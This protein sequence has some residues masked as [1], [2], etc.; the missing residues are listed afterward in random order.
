MDQYNEVFKKMLDSIYTRHIRS[1]Y[2]TEL[3]FGDGPVS[4]IVYSTV[5]AN[6]EH[7]TNKVIDL[8]VFPAEP[9]QCVP[10]KKTNEWLSLYPELGERAIEA[11]MERFNDY[12]DRR[13]R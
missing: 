4:V 8:R 9:N 10:V 6:T 1:H 11:A 5:E 12:L 3:D 7:M 13:D 2:R